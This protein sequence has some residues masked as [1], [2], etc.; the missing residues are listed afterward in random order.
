M[1]YT[2]KS[3]F[4]MWTRIACEQTPPPPSPSPIFPEGEGG[5]C[6]QARLETGIN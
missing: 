5:V 2:W 4:V 1:A 6:T 3:I